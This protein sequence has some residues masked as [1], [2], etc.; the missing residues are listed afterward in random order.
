MLYIAYKMVLLNTPAFKF[1]T[2][3]CPDISYDEQ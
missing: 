3:H 1:I 2:K